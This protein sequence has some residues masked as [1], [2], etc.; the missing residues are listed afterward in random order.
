MNDR[1]KLKKSIIELLDGIDK[2][3]CEYKNGWWETDTGAEFGKVKLEELLNFVTE[4]CLPDFIEFINDKPTDGYY[5]WK[6]DKTDE[7]PSIV[8][9]CG[10]TVFEIEGDELFTDVDD[11]SGIWSGPLTCQPTKRLTYCNGGIMSK[12][13]LMD[14]PECMQPDGAEPC[15][16]YNELYMHSRKLEGLLHQ[17]A[18]KLESQVVRNP[19]LPKA[20]S[21]LVKKSFSL[22]K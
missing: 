3:E 13:N 11:W 4:S 12:I 5:W 20:Y 16:A 1:E 21:E 19:D 9:V 18:S 6:S 22:I 17:C 14:L 10:N 7:Y 15:K 8:K 2:N